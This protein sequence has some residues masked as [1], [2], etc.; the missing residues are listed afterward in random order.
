M[1]GI[2][3]TINWEGM[4]TA[5]LGIDVGGNILPYVDAGVAFANITRDATDMDPDFGTDPT[6]VTNTQ[7]GWT[8]GVG[9][10]AQI[11]DH[12]TGFVSYNYA[13]YGNAD[14]N[15]GG[16][17]TPSVHT[18]DNIVKAGINYHF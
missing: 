3:Q 4:I 18:T 17:Y 7:V 2:T 5:K 1:T 11:A 9:L 8:V 12:V 13:D 14:F 16:D 15:T 10:E 6:S